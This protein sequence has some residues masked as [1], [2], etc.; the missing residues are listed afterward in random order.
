MIKLSNGIRLLFLSVF[1]ISLIGCGV[2]KGVVL[3]ESHRG[4]YSAYGKSWDLV[5]LS[6]ERVYFWLME[7]KTELKEREIYLVSNKGDFINLKDRFFV[8]QKS[9]G[10][11]NYTY[12]YD[13]PNIVSHNEKLYVKLAKPKNLTNCLVRP[14]DP[15]FPETI[16]YFGEFD[17]GANRFVIDRF[18]PDSEAKFRHLT[19]TG[20]VSHRDA[21]KMLLN[22]SEPFEC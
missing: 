3:K 13:S 22:Y 12:T 2:S 18:F 4:V 5:V 17:Q 14:G 11:K 21:E 20:K 1:M 10:Y 7:Q 9:G 16:Y 19:H 6:R 8:L 15:Q